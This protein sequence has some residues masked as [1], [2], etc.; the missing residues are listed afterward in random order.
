MQLIQVQTYP[1][2]LIS[3]EEAKIYLQEDRDENDDLIEALI[4][5]AI[6]IIRQKTNRQ[7]KR[8]DLKLITDAEEL[9][10]LVYPPVISVSRVTL[11]GET[12]GAED[13]EL[14]NSE[15]KTYL[16]L[17]VDFATTDEVEIEYS[18]GYGEGQLPSMLKT[19]ILMLVRSHYDQRGGA[20]IGATISEIPY[21]I[22]YILDEFRIRYV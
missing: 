18:A 20:I 6:S 3:L 17:K 21:T 2:E 19:V 8:T 1:D 7:I 5:S 4:E 9:V 13:Y 14:L 10:E 16:K 11:N 15:Y 12:L 22:D